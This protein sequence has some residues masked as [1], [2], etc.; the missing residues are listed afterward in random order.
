MAGVVLGSNVFSLAALLGLGAVVAGR[1]QLHRTTVVLSGADAV[2][3]AAVCLAVALGWLSAAGSPALPRLRIMDQVATV[4]RGHDHFQRYGRATRVAKR[5]PASLAVSNLTGDEPAW[6]AFQDRD[7]VRP[8][9][10]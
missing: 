4:P 10:S 3:V 5:T 7:R 9:S 1:I 6:R 2:C 8:L